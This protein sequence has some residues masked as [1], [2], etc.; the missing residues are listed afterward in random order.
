[1]KKII[2]FASLAL[3]T[4]ACS[5]APVDNQDYNYSENEGGV[6]I[7][8]ET[9]VETKAGSNISGSTDELLENSILKIYDNSGSLIRNYEPATDSPETVYLVSG[10]Y[11]LT[12]DFGSGLV[13][14]SDRS[15]LTYSGEADFTITAGS[16]TAVGVTC[17]VEN[18]VVTIDFDETTLN[19][20]LNEGYKVTLVAASS[21]TDEML[22]DSYTDKLTFTEDGSG[23]FIL[24]EDVKTVA[25]RFDGVKSSNGVEI[26]V[27]GVV[28]NANAG[29]ENILSFMYDEDEQ[30]LGFMGD[31]IVDLTTE[32][33]NDD[34]DFSYEE[35]DVSVEP[36]IEEDGFDS[37]DGELLVEDDTEF[38][39]NIAS[40]TYLT[41]ID[42]LVNG[43]IVSPLKDGELQDV[44]GA[45]FTPTEESLT[46]ASVGYKS[47]VLT[48][49]GSIF[50]KFE[51]AGEHTIEIN[52]TDEN[53]TT[54]TKT[55]TAT[56]TEEVVIVD[57]INSVTTDLWSNAATFTATIA[58]SDYQTAVM[59]VRE[60]G[61]TDWQ[62][63]SLTKSGDSY[64]ATV[65][66]AWT[67]YTNDAGLTYYTPTGG[68]W[69]GTTYE[70]QLVVDG[71][72]V[73]S[74]EFGSA[75]N[76]VQAIPDGD[77][78]DSSI[79]CYGTGNSG[80]TWDSGN[81]KFIS[82]YTLCSQTT[83]GSATCAKLGTKTVMSVIAAGNVFY[84]SFKY[85][86]FTGTVSFGR[87]FT[88]TSRPRSLKVK[89]AASLASGS[90]TSPSG[91][92][93]SQDRGRIFL[94]IVDWDSQHATASG[95]GDPSGVWDPTTQTSTDEGKIIGYAS[96]FIDESTTVTEL[97]DLELPI[98][99]YDTETKPSGNYTIVISC[100]SSAYGDYKI[101]VSGSTLY[102][103]DFE[104][105]Y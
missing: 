26:S 56:T 57:A 100:A 99:Y 98:Y 19:K 8:I 17:N 59:Q 11:N 4:A 82:T 23:Y 90:I 73:A 87:A 80:S 15:D 31:I 69:A 76:G 51:E 67:S 46:K 88:W 32:E 78:D 48:I 21:I 86:S 16:T 24:P 41:D 62:E 94:A 89:Y 93:Y 1:M 38:S 77:M 75:N 65:G 79:A 12:L 83:L 52:V 58:N 63:A 101:G 25:W 81:F 84:G 5:D 34:F 104:F 18:T 20:Y 37:E 92:T 44:E 35:E 72:V 29:E 9:K 28:N 14:S 103:D 54:I 53:S 36:S 85:S 68:I 47:G 91:D 74:T 97:H 45:T 70:C 61:T 33:F 49:Q 42:V 7:A 6:S 13:M 55:L 39:Y 50:S 95:T 3:F 43:E 102:V 22:S 2:I 40:D 60:E 105:G 30:G 71:V 27:S 10:D 64:T 96:L 66:T